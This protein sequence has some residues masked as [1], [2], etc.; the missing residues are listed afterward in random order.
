MFAHLVTTGVL[1]PIAGTL[2][3]VPSNV[4]L[5]PSRLQTSFPSLNAQDSRKDHSSDS[6]TSPSHPYHKPI[7]HA[8]LP[9]HGAKPE[10][11]HPIVADI[12]SPAL[13]TRNTSHNGLLDGKCNGDVGT[14]SRQGSAGKSSA[15]KIV[16]FSLSHS[17][18]RRVRHFVNILTTF[19]YNTWFRF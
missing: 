7:H 4:A 17:R 9:S 15:I 14:H 12:S 6:F 11:R 19:L 10:S 18:A 3:S 13:R 16:S 2:N 5:P 1:G 8:A